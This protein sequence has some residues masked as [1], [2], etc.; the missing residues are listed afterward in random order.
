MENLPRHISSGTTEEKAKSRHWASPRRVSEI[1][2]NIVFCC[3]SCDTSVP[4]REHIGFGL[5]KPESLVKRH[6]YTETLN[7][8]KKVQSRKKKGWSGGGKYWWFRAPRKV[9]K[10]QAQRCPQNLERPYTTN[11]IN[12]DG[13]ELVNKDLKRPQACH[14]SRDPF[15][16]TS[17][18]WLIR[19]GLK[20]PR[21]RAL[22]AFPVL[23]SWNCQNSDSL[24]LPTPWFSRKCKAFHRNV[25]LHS[26]FPAQINPFPS[27]LPCLRC[28]KYSSIRLLFAG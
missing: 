12:Q 7:Q 19:P 5:T 6:L 18:R 2:G 9:G 17:D 22:A 1:K 13:F 26:P 27:N 4:E 11:K 3:P 23:C 10:E 20:T 14:L 16:N 28:T 8:K 21:N 25:S 24:C 15:N